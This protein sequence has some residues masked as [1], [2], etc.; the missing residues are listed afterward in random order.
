VAA[1][2]GVDRK[3]LHRRKIPAPNS[4]LHLKGGLAMPHVIVKLWPGRSERQKK[5]LA[6]RITRVVM[7]VL[8]Y[9]DE[10]VSVGFEE[11]SANDWKQ[12]VYEPD[13]VSQPRNV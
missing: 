10:S 12:K 5:E 11:I 3:K 1:G 13:I 2:G 9:G 6:E 7:E 4:Q 8:H